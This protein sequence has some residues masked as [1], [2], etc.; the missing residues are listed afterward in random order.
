MSDERRRAVA[1]DAPAASA[2]KVD[3]R[4]RGSRV[5]MIVIVAGALAAGVAG[6]MFAFGS[7]KQADENGAKAGAA[8]GD[9]TEPADGTM[10]MAEAQDVIAGGLAEDVAKRPCDEEPN[11]K[12]TMMRLENGDYKGAGAVVDAFAKNCP[13]PFVRLLRKGYYAHEQ[14][15]EWPQAEAIAAA[16]IRAEPDEGSF[17]WWR[18]Q[19]RAEQKHV[20]PAAADFRQAMAGTPFEHSRG[21]S[22]IDFAGIAEQVAATCDAAFALQTFIDVKEGNVDVSVADAQAR[23]FLAGKCEAA[24]GAGGFSLPPTA[25]DMVDVKIGK[26]TGRFVVGLTTGYTLLSPAFAAKAGVAAAGDPLDTSHVGA[27]LAGPEAVV[28]KITI[29]AASAPDI[30]VLVVPGLPGDVDGV[31]G[32]SFL[33]RFPRQY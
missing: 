20:A 8:A 9:G 21:N 10:G 15:G 19:A 13:K 4:A 12:L 26:A 16:L 7:G 32:Q 29:G 33:Y 25:T 23:L 18:G 31:I 30:H 27:L 3:L 5:W 2:S 17:W 6:A 24:R 1:H 22:L 14:A 11:Y 28:P